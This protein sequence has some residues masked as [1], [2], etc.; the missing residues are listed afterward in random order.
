MALL[1]HPVSWHRRSPHTT[2]QMQQALPSVPSKNG[3]SVPSINVYAVDKQ[4][5]STKQGL[6]RGASVPVDL[7]EMGG[8]LRTD[9]YR[10]GSEC[11]W[12][13]QGLD[14]SRLRRHRTGSEC[15]SD[16][17]WLEQKGS[18]FPLGGSSLIAGSVLTLQN[19]TVS[20]P[21]AW[22]AAGKGVSCC[23]FLNYFLHI[24][25]P[26]TWKWCL[27]LLLFYASCDHPVVSGHAFACT[28][29]QRYALSP[30]DHG[31]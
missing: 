5:K 15:P 1:L 30:A 27:P 28:T 11:P 8:G 16:G 14:A 22:Q 31:G 19:E 20:Y 7:L 25:P 23:K 29:T 17:L 2:S 12:D 26:G 18:A 3:Y 9:V 13:G 21:Q 10:P 6:L 24:R 4:L